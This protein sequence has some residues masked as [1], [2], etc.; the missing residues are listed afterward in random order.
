MTHR[1][2][3][4]ALLAPLVACAVEPTTGTDTSA[5]VTVDDTD[6][7]TECA[8]IL[9]YVNGATA[10]ELD[11]Y[12]PSNVVANLVARRAVTPFVDLADLSS[13]SGIAQAR[14]WAI[15]ERA[16][17]GSFI[18]ASCAGVYEELAVSADD[19]TAILAYANTASTDALLEVVRFEKH[20]VVPAI[21]AARP[22]ASLQSLVDV[23]GIGTSTFR[24][25]R[26]AA[27]ESPFDELVSRV[28][29]ADEWAL[30]RTDFD[31]FA[32]LYD[33]P[34]QPTHLTCW[35][36]ASSIVVGPLGGTI[37]PEPHRRRR[38]LRPRRRG[39]RDRRSLRR[40]RRRHRR[41]GAPGRPGRRP[42]LLR[43]LP[44]LRSRSVER[45]DPH[46]LRQHRHRLP[47]PGRDL[48]GRVTRVARAAPA[49]R[50][51]LTAPVTRWRRPRPWRPRSRRRWAPAPGGT[52]S[53][54]GCRRGSRA[55]TAPPP[56]GTHRRQ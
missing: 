51:A 55:G 22:I 11:A 8:G 25:L 4:T 54:R 19:A 52:G 23:Y 26:D 17:L 41:P 39:G 36:I 10:T 12:L 31:W 28:N 9:T 14:L 38:G 45:R 49:G 16:R 2:I 56:R 53:R 32:T 34:G 24:A 48:V 20:T 15:A 27:I 18:G 6:L 44:G 21:I 29:A 46:L 40:G 47:G 3:L 50:R 7:A 37:E 1:L 30:M 13:V 33:M 42:D 35:G 5:L 43:L